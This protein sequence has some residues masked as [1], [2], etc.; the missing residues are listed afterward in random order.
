MRR[1]AGRIC[2]PSTPEPTRLSASS[3]CSFHLPNFPLLRRPPAS[4]SNTILL[5]EPFMDVYIYRA[6]RWCGP[7]VIKALVPSRKA[8]PAAIDMSPAEALQQIVSANGFTSE[9][10]YDSDDLPKGPIA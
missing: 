5:G 6:G 2:G 7:C 10:D 4:G 8:A 9:S 1:P 3:A